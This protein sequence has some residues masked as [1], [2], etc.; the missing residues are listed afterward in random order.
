MISTRKSLHRNQERIPFFMARRQRRQART[1]SD[2]AVFRAPRPSP[3][4]AA[5]LA[6]HNK[7]INPNTTVMPT[8][9]K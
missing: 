9:H 1:A 7:A 2:P 6:R 5:E 4:D 3:D 8:K